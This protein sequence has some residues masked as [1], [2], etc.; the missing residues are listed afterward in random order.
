MSNYMCC[1]GYGSSHESFRGEWPLMTRSGHIE[2]GSTQV[3][4]WISQSRRECSSGIITV[5]DW[6]RIFMARASTW[7][8]QQ[9]LVAHILETLSWVYLACCK[10][11]LCI[12]AE[13]C[14]GQ[15]NSLWV[16]SCY[17]KIFPFK[18]NSIERLKIC[19]FS[20]ALTN[21]FDGVSRK[22]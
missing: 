5:H 8:F 10:D 15:Q 3:K 4:V 19:H 14:K 20:E 17:S 6:D 12:Q 1:R 11:F 21:K 9:W 18:L 2:H 13:V 7:T 22:Q 16:Y